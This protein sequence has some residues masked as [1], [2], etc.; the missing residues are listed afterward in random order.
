MH[1]ILLRVIGQF[2]EGHS[3]FDFSLNVSGKLL[4]FEV[5]DGPEAE[6]HGVKHEKLKQRDLGV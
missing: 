3:F 2:D 5:F 4:V 1:D 6:V